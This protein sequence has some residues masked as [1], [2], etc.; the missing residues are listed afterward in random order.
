MAGCRCRTSKPPSQD[1]GP[2]LMQN[3][4]TRVVIALALLTLPAANLLAQNS[5][6]SALINEALDK[7]V[8]LDLNTVLPEAMRTIAKNTGVRIEASSAVW[9]LLPWGDQTNITAKIEN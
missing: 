7:P 3:S 9:D 6:T 5:P 8:S 1:T 4:I 2:A